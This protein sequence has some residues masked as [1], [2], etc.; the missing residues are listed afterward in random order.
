MVSEEKKKLGGWKRNYWRGKVIS[1]AGKRKEKEK[2][3][4][5]QMMDALECCK[6]HDGPVTTKVME[7]LKSFTETEIIAGAFFLKRTTAPNIR[8]KYEVG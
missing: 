1:L 3:M 7:K 6:Q 4:T 8:L 5:Q 2:K